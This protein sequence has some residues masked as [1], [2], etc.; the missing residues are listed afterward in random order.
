M[1]KATTLSM[2]TLGIATIIAAAIAT[3]QQQ[4]AFAEEL[5]LGAVEAHLGELDLVENLK[6]HLDEFGVDEDLRDFIIGE[7]EE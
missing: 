3:G 1:I 2:I 6:G 5:D 7:I 4:I